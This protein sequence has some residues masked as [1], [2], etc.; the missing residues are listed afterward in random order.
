MTQKVSFI[1]LTGGP[2]GGKTTAK[3][4]VAQW[5]QEQN[6]RAICL[7]E[8][9]T[10]LI[11]AGF[12][13]TGR[14]FQLQVARMQAAF[15]ERARLEAE[16]HD[17]QTV[18]ICDRGLHDGAAY[19]QRG[20]DFPRVLAEA[21]LDPKKTM[22]RYL[23][24]IHLL[25]AAKGAEKFYTCENN[26]AR[27]ESPAQARALDER[28]Q[29]AWYRHSCL[30]IV[31][32]ST[33]FEEKLRRALIALADMLGIPKPREKERKW[34][35]ASV[36]QSNLPQER[37]HVD[38]VQHYLHTEEDEERVRKSV[39]QDGTVVYTHAFK[40]K[41]VGDRAE[42]QRVVSRR[43]YEACYAARAKTTHPSGSDAPASLLGRQALG[44][45]CFR[46]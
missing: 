23:G 25:T 38:I 1:V 36:E 35:V 21:G 11:E 6:I 30:R 34:L 20:E 27:N 15:E 28:T 12:N 37:Y 40:S 3:A 5:L 8:A 22:E 41:E 9:A 19:M 33:G 18:V 45:R 29:Y 2:C 44:A 26:A 7:P 31:D 46:R 42:R 32:N 10:I 39:S 4:R 14:V 16:H 17:G 24:V 43:E 13:R